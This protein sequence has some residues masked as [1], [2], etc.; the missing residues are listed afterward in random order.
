[1]P[2]IALPSASRASSQ[3]P[4]GDVEAEGDEADRADH[5]RL[6]RRE[7]AEADPVADEHVGLAER[8]RHQP[9]QGAR[10]S[11]REASRSR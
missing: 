11:A 8:Q 3:V 1:M 6:K 4:C 10:W 9:L 7:G 5:D 2:S